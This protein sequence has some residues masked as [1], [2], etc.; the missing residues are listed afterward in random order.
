MMRFKLTI[1]IFSLTSLIGQPLFAFELF[2]GRSVAM[3]GAY[4]QIGRGVESVFWNPANLGFSKGSE[5]SLM[6]F[7]VGVNAYNNSLNLKQYNQY[8]GKFL[9]SEDKQTILDL[10]PSKG[11]NLSMDADVLA[12]GI[13]WGNFAFTVSGSGTSD[14]LFPKDPIHVL[15]FGNEINDTILLSDS[16]GEAF[17]SVDIGFS[18]GKSVWKKDKKEILC[19]I[20]ARYMHGLVYQKVK[21]A[22]GEIFALET[23][24]NGDGDFAVQSAEG[25]KGCGLDFGLALEYNDNWTFGLSF[26]NLINQIKWG[27]KTEKR[28]YQVQIDSLLAENFDLDSLVIED[29]Y[30]EEIDPFTTRI[31]TLMHV[32]VAYQGKRLLWAFDVKHGFKEGMGISR[33][34]RASLGAEYEPLG[35]LDVRGGISIG[36]NEGVTVANGVGFNLGAYH[37]DLGIAMQKGLWPTRSKGIN[38]AISNGFHF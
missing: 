28:G 6:L 20:N 23:G 25:G 13:S 16:H 2:S 9:T 1:L 4:T 38:L 27:E 37:L 36:G 10:I 8:N 26:I 29:S 14:L 18:Y 24:V 17:A 5:K 21:Q 35:W 19:G 33:K 15:F 7:S 32:G 31:P 11:F 12:F 22:Q 30:T 3:G 34:L